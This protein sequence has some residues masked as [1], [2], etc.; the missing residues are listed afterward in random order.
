MCLLPLLVISDAKKSNNYIFLLIGVTIWM[1]GLIF[2]IISDNQKSR[3]NSDKNNK[4]KFINT[5]LWSLSRHPNYFGEFILWTGIT[6]IALPY[7][8]GIHYIA[9]I[10]PVFIYLMLNKISG[11]NLLEEIADQRW[12]DEK[13]Y[14]DYKKQ[15]PIFFPKLFKLQTKK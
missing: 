12:G 13:S 4:G 1:F 6:V 2:E 5:G 10:S 11:V 8:S 7:F 3:F 9:C 14:L 15:T